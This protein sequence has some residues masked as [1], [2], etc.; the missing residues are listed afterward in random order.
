MIICSEAIKTRTRTHNHTSTLLGI[1]PINL[2][3]S[4]IN[5]PSVG[6][7][8]NSQDIPVSCNIYTQFI[9]QIKHLNINE[10]L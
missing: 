1:T 8:S 7:Q 6:A 3:K 5:P 10:I 9:I 4:K 2:M